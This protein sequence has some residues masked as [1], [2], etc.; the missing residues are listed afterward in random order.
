MGSAAGVGKVPAQPAG[1]MRLNTISG[2]TPRGTSLSVVTRL[3]SAM[4]PGSGVVTTTTSACCSIASTL[5][6]RREIPG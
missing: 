6:E 1:S 3:A 4:G 5:R 2:G